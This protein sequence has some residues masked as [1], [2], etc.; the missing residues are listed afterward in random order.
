[1]NYIKDVVEKVLPVGIGEEFNVIVDGNYSRHNPFKFTET[2]L[3]DTFG[4]VFNKYIG[5]IITGEYKI[6]KAPFVPKDGERYWTYISFGLG[7]GISIGYYD[8]AGSSFDQERRL[9]GVIFRTREDAEDY[10]PTWRKRLEG[11]EC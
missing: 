5:R 7:R 8:W 2:D 9:M 3:V 4:D 6:E 1:M 10:I 11:E